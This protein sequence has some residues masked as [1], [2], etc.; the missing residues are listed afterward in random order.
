[1]P[2]TVASHQVAAF[3]TPINGATTDANV[4]RGNDN[5]LRTGYV[6]HD[7]DPGI[8]LQSSTLASRPAFGA[9]GRKW[10]TA[11][12]GSYRLFFD[13][14]S[15]WQEL[16]YLR[17]DAGGTV[18]AQTTFSVTGN[19]QIL[20]TDGTV[21]QFVGYADTNVAYSGT[22]TNH[23]YAL[24]TNNVERVRVLNGGNVGIGTAT[25]SALLHVAGTF[26]ATG[27]ATFNGNVTFDTN[28]LF[29]DATNNRVG[30]GTATPSTA[31]HVAS[32]TSTFAGP[33]I[34]NSTVTIGGDVL[35]SAP[36][37]HDLGRST[38]PFQETWTKHYV[39]PDLSAGSSRG[40]MTYSLTTGVGT[41]PSNIGDNTFF[42]G[43]GAY[44]IVAGDRLGGT[45]SFVDIVIMATNAS[46]PVVVSSTTSRGAP[47][48]RTY[49]VSGGR[50]RLAMGL[51]SY[52]VAV[53]TT[54]FTY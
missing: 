37:T 41:G 48:T 18:L 39:S 29:V 27:D 23:A 54:V 14:G 35:P 36:S 19:P 3:T 11:D 40:A 33:I 6:N 51:N 24:L 31:F 52:N 7:A 28:T 45:D 26:L 42:T 46:T 5:T 2:Q 4:V 13:T 43:S 22:Q 34:T 25:P 15:A 17:T 38:D 9:A 32:G 44:Y 12:T 30:V 53:W 16:T 47:D 20:S 1:M 49:S 10:L 8:H 50:L 21:T